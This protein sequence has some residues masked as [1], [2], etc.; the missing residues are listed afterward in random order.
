MDY[1]YWMMDYGQWMMDYGLWMMGLGDGYWMM[2]NGQWI[3]D[4]GS[5]AIQCAARIT[6]HRAAS[7]FPGIVFSLIFLIC[8]RPGGSFFDDF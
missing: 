3:M 7:L 1:G 8:W 5:W 2:D 6:R 4:N